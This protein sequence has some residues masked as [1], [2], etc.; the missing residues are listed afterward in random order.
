[1]KLASVL[2][3]Y[4]NVAKTVNTSSGHKIYDNHDRKLGNAPIQPSIQ[5][6]RLEKI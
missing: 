4:E 2:K 6:F 3:K 1:M 5:V